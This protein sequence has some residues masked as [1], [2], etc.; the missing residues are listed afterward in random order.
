M[1]HTRPPLG[2]NR[3]PCLESGRARQ[4]RPPDDHLALRRLSA[5]YAL[6][7]LEKR[8]FLQS[9]E[10]ETQHGRGS[11][12][13]PAEISEGNV[14]VLLTAGLACNF[15]VSRGGTRRILG[16]HV[17]GD[18]L[19]LSGFLL[20]RPNPPVAAASRCTVAYLPF[21]KLREVMDRHARI[22]DAL[23]R[24]LGLE[25]STLQKWMETRKLSEA[26]A[27]L[28]CELFTR[29]LAVQL[30]RPGQQLDLELTQH[31]L[32]DAIG[33]SLVATNKSASALRREGLL[34]FKGAHRI[35]DFDGLAMHCGFSAAY[36]ET[37]R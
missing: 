26:I 24:Q 31:D 21:E 5:T 3:A 16:F 1:E 34:D 28:Y 4:A 8:A 15:A 29:H 2:P 6:S 37:R 20:R 36:L 27:H 25:F 10:G 35:L 17:P 7:E 14:L 18:I 9:I 13:I 12:I 23:T 30:V 11:Q 22:E 33:A 19:N 32:A